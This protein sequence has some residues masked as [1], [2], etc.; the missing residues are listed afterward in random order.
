[1]EPSVP[2]GDDFIW[3]GSPDEWLCLIV[4]F[5]D[6]AIDGRLEIDDGPEDAVFQPT[7]CKDGE[8]AF[9]RVQP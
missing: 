6:E 1:M 3:I 2:C 5:V 9:D 8:E 7:A 4:V